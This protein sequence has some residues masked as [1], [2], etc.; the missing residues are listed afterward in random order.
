MAFQPFQFDALQLSELARQ[1]NCRFA[2]ADPFPHVVID[3]FL[4]P[5]VLD[6]ILEE[7]PSSQ[8][9]GWFQ[10]DDRF[11]KKLASVSPQQIPP[12][13]RHLIHELNSSI[14][15]SFLESLT[16]IEGIVPDPHLEGGGLHQIVAGGFLKIHADF[17][18]HDRLK[19]DRRL[20]LIVYVN[21][22][23]KPDYGGDLELWDRDMKRCVQK[24]LPIF[25][26]CVIFATTDWSYH[27]HPDPL[28]C[29]PEINRKSIAL[30]YY[31]RGRPK[32]ELTDAHAT[33]YQE[34]AGEQLK[35]GF[36]LVKFIKLFIPPIILMA[37]RRIFKS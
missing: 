33:L 8:E 14:F 7:F 10:F 34:R 3:D 21:K 35:T 17:N 15:V 6:S 25:N 30:Y 22:E 36:K 4:P 28:S 16:S 13:A 32:S 24:I 1:L 19:L 9:V 37:F 29:P 5:K 31:T 20:N 2:N 18:L 23:W 11:G 26:R 27:G 12:N